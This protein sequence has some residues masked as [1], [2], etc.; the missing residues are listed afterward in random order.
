VDDGSDS[1][2]IE[3]MRTGSLDAADA[4]F[5]RHWAPVWRAA[6]AVLGDRAAADDAAQR[7]VERAIRRLDTF[8]LGGSFGAWI[9]R[10]AVNQAIDML[11]RRGRETPL[12]DDAA[13]PDPYED[14]L[15]R[16]ALVAA[17]GRLE[18]GRRVV[19]AMRY[20]LDMTPGEIA[21]ALEVPVGTVSSRLSRALAELREHLEV[22]ER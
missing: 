3:A 2:L 17:V 13:A 19:V 16:E 7:A 10:I 15:Q 22:S 12:H 18:E 1:D 20:W 4:L 9:R 14:V 6:Y 11:R 5:G 8:Q 21:E